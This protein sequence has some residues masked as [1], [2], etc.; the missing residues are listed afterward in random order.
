MESQT[1]SY[2]SYNNQNCEAV[3]FG[4]LQTKYCLFT[5]EPKKPLK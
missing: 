2:F 4:I 5:L 3:Q 1:T